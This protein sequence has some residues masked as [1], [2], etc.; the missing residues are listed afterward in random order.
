MNL[1]DLLYYVDNGVM[2]LRKV[3]A[4]LIFSMIMIFLVGCSNDSIVLVSRENGSG[5]RDTFIQKT[6]ILEEGDGFK[7]DR[8]SKNSIV[9]MQTETVIQTVSGNKES[10][11]YISTGSLDDSIKVLSIDG[12][13]PNSENIKSGDYKLARKFNMVLKDYENPLA[14]DFIDFIFSDEGSQIISRNYI[15]LSEK[16]EKYEK[17]DLSGRLILAG[18]TSVYPLAEVLGEAYQKINPNVEIEIQQTGSS[19]GITSAIDGTVDIGL[20]SRELKEKEKE[21]LITI[22]IANDGIAVV[23]N[24]AQK[25]SNIKLDDLRKIFTEEI[26][27]WEEVEVE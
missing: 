15:S 1:T 22:P 5:T 13:Y 18:S 24:K 23:V 7:K 16:S 6:G 14:K 17:K 3:K 11:G 25:I 27:R 9:Q 8:T 10:I 12:V 21:K 4:L 2:H 20:S 26:T 19:A